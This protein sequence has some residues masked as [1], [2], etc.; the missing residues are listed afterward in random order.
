MAELVQLI[1]ISGSHHH[2]RHCRRIIVLVQLIGISGS[3]HD[4]HHACDTSSSIGSITGSVARVV[5]KILMIYRLF[6]KG[7]KY[8]GK[9]KY[10][11]KRVKR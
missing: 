4:D 9:M 6:V 1:D 11:L 5:S 3:H 2:H 10:C 7:K 8:S